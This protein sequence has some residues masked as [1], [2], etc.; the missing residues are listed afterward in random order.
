[1]SLFYV[2]ARNIYY[3]RA[4]FGLPATIVHELAHWVV[5][6]CLFS[7]MDSFSILPR[8]E[9]NQIIYGQVVYAPTFSVFCV[10][11]SLAP[12]IINPAVAWFIYTI[13][14]GYFLLEPLRWYL[15]IIITFGAIPSTADFKTALRG[16]F[17]WSGLFCVFAAFFM[18][19][20]DNVLTHYIRNVFIYIQSVAMYLLYEVKYL[21][22]LL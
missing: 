8:F 22:T 18:Y 5:A 17:S 7:R 11:I 1:M 13:Q 4:L 14:T 12:L 20:T 21:L 19:Y 3:I 15:I 16:L 2:N 6:F 9:G 10:P